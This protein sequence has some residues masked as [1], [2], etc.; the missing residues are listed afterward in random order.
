MNLD[1][2]LEE[3]EDLELRVLKLEEKVPQIDG[4]LISLTKS[5]DENH[6]KFVVGQH[7]NHSRSTKSKSNHTFLIQILDSE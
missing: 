6:K 3:R 5:T 1:T 7:D 2:R 4:D